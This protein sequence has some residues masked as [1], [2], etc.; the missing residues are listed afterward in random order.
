M[1]QKHLISLAFVL[2]ATLMIVFADEEK[3]TS[4]YDYINV[5]E[6]LANPKL[7]NQY[8]DCF[9]ESGPCSTPDAKFFKGMFAEA[10]VTK[11]KKCTEKQVDMLNKVS[12]WYSE[13][14]PD[15]WKKVVERA[16]QSMQK[17]GGA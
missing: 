15:N 17:K 7:R 2:L 16:M 6:V 3:Y 12:A 8:F 13:N 9:M 14:E 11:C 10:F 1:F 5:D 4:K